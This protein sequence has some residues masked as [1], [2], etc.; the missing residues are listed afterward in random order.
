MPPDK[1]I[2]YDDNYIDACFYAWYK[3]GRPSL[4]HGSQVAPYLP[5]AD[6]GRKPIN[7]TVNA[8][9]RKFGWHE[10][11]DALDGELSRKLDKAAIAER[12]KTIKKLA[13]AGE[14]LKD[15]GIEYLKNENPFQDNPSA[16]VRA[17]VSGAEMVFK[18]SG[19]A[20]ALLAIS[21]MS[22]AQLEKEAMRLLGK[23][24][25]EESTIDVIPE[26]VPEGVPEDIPSE[27]VDTESDDND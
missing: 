6:D 4:A 5:F 20:E 1:I 10:R 3:N 15:K 13:Q 8:W 12:A 23:N 27:D 11:A 17:V 7:Y 2:Q 19:Y 21:Q 26:D 18:Y 14:T 9:I 16:A 24:E 22:P 25:N